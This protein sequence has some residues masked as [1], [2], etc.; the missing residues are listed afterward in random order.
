MTTNQRSENDN[1]TMASNSLKN[2]HYTM[3]SAQQHEYLDD[4]SISFS[5]G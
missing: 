5:N 1:E 2:T 3:L 4:V